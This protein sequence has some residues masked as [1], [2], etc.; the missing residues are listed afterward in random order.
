M[1]DG[2]PVIMCVFYTWII[3]VQ[4][5]SF[6]PNSLPE[7]STGFRF[8]QHSLIIIYSFH[9]LLIYSFHYRIS[10]F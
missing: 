10:S 4:V 2:I 5:K 1:A 7:S 9:H 6:S 8:T 3:S